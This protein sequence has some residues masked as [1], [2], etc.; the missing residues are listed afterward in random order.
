M[1][2]L[3]LSLFISLTLMGCAQTATKNEAPGAGSQNAGLAAQQQRIT[4]EKILADRKTIDALQLRLR[5]LNES[6]IPQNNYPLAKAQCWLD[7]AKTQYH[8]NDRTGY[9]EESLTES[10]KIIQALEANKNANVG[11]DTPLV[12]RSTR[13]RDDLWM[14]LGKYKNNAATLSCNAR[15]VACA[16]I[17][18]VRAGHA[19]EQTGW[20]AATPH[21]MMVEDGLRRAGVEAAACAPAVAQAVPVP[22][23][24]PSTAAPAPIVREVTKE[25]FVILADTLFKFDKSG[26]DEM[27]PGGKERLA[28]VANRL[29][30][31]QSIATL[32]IAG[33][34]DRLGTDSYNDPLSARRAATVLEQLSSLGVKAAKTE[35]VGKGKREPVTTQCGDKLARAELITCLQPDRRVTIEVTGVVK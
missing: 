22:A 29:K 1:K 14:E 6:G 25:T 12:A 32:S 18:L 21:V 17:R 23:P 9:I 3:F 20:R 35:A 7:T 31:Y 10:Q 24:V 2:P 15:T 19:E 33:H 30:T 16:E 4:E 5:K 11:F 27:L 34:T 13:L 28:A 8:E 26:R